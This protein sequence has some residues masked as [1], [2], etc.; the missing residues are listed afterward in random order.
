MTARRTLLCCTTIALAAVPPA[1]GTASASAGTGR[2][3]SVPN[4]ALALHRS[5]SR[6]HLRQMDN[7]RTTFARLNRSVHRRFPFAAPVAVRAVDATVVVRL[8][9]APRLAGDR[10]LVVGVVD[11]DEGAG[12]ERVFD[13]AR[14]AGR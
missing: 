5:E 4:R 13:T 12:R 7:H 14:F 8:A 9:G 11:V 6:W 10:V 3:N 2:S 1:L